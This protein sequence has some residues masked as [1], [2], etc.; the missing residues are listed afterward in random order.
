MTRP[1]G[2]DLNQITYD[3]TVEGTNGFKGLDL[4][5]CACRTMDRES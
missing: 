3:Y 2:Y 4:V 5:D 1:F